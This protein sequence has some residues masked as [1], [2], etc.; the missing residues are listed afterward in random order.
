MAVAHRDIE[1]NFGYCESDKAFFTSNE[2]KWINRMR[3]LAA[4]HPEECK[5]IEQPESND[6]YIYCKLP[7]SWLY[8]R[9]PKKH[10]MT[11]EQK[12]AGAERLRKARE[13]KND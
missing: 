2:R 11:E 10:V 7:T 6:G 8:I 5:I 9:P 1:T 13:A 4:K 3:M 12:L